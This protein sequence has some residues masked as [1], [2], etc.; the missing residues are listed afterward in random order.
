MM[1]FHFLYIQYPEQKKQQCTNTNTLCHDSHWP[2]AS[3]IYAVHPSLTMTGCNQANQSSTKRVDLFKGTSWQSQR[4]RELY[5]EKYTLVKGQTGQDRI[6][7]N[8]TKAKRANIQRYSK[9][10]PAIALWTVWVAWTSPACRSQIIIVRN[11][12]IMF[13]IRSRA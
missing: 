3:N 10:L 12:F 11:G 5:R 6:E 4:R 2:K 1:L 7:Q 13:H 8:R 9:M